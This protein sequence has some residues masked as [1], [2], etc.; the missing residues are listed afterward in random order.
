MPFRGQSTV[1]VVM[2]AGQ[3]NTPQD[4]TFA[5][6]SATGVNLLLGGFI[7]VGVLTGNL[8]VAAPTGMIQGD[9]I[10]YNFIQD[11]TGGRVVTLPAVFKGPALVAG[12]ANLKLSVAY[13]FD[14]TNW[15]PLSNSG[16]DG[17]QPPVSSGVTS[18][19]TSGV[20]ATVPSFFRLL[21][22]GTGTVVVDSRDKLGA[23]SS[24]LYTFT[25]TAAT[26][27]V[28]FPFLGLTATQIRVTMTGSATAEI[29]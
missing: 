26:N 3:D 16:W 14:G 7:N 11:A 29:I 24:A 5:N 22:T 12:T 27:Q 20:W 10:T 6:A 15:M 17:I 8:T 23:V 21:L 9:L 28:E 4:I 1:T 25:L 2:P 18:T 13:R 19:L